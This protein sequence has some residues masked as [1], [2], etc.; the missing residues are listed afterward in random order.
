MESSTPDHA[1][2]HAANNNN[3]KP[4]NN[5]NLIT[6]GDHLRHVESMAT[7]PSGVGNIFHLN[8]VILGESLASEENDLVFPNNS[9]P[10]PPRTSLTLLG[11]IRSSQYPQI[12]KFLST[13]HSLFLSLM[14]SPIEQG[15]DANLGKGLMTA[16]P[17]QN[18]LAEP[19][20]SSTA[21]APALVLSNSGKRIDQAG[22]KKYVKQVTGR[23]NNTELHLAAQ[24]ADLAAVKKILDDID[25]QMVGTVSGT[26][27]DTEVA[28]VRAAV[29][30]EVNELEETTLFTAA[31]KGHLDVVKELLKYSNK[32][33]FTKKN[34]SGFDPLHAATSQGHHAIIQVLLDHDPGLSKTRPDKTTNLAAEYITFEMVISETLVGGLIGRNGSNI[35]RI[36]NEPGAMIKVYGGKG[37]Q[38]HRQVQFCGS[39][40]QVALAKQRADEYI[41]SQPVQQPGAQQPVFTVKMRQETPISFINCSNRHLQNQF[42][43]TA[44]PRCF[45]SIF[46][47]A[48]HAVGFPMLSAAIFEDKKWKS[49]KVGLLE[50]EPDVEDPISSLFKNLMDYAQGKQVFDESSER[51]C[52][53][54]FEYSKLGDDASRI[55]ASN[56]VVAASTSST[57][58]SPFLPNLRDHHYEQAQENDAESDHGVAVGG[59]ACMMSAWAQ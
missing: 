48:S 12:K 2:H 42:M 26:E 3:K 47:N 31:D 51:E 38:K 9:R 5:P 29:V 6:T 52:N 36:R 41:Y 19:S 40:Q 30:N 58:S 24:R 4:C 59:M 33:T 39:A 49:I 25:S 10:Y 14:A 18:T 46:V 1:D 54:D 55:C 44:D 21:S 8:A 50:L 15:G 17:S 45:I 32:E 35:S 22:K 43:L 37:E 34:R 53:G 20:P 57:P 56:D 27:F 16:Q 28:E 23:H 7:M 11:S 13:R